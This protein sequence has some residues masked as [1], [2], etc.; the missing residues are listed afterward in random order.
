MFNKNF[1]PTPKPL[2]QRLLK[3]YLNPHYKHHRY[4][5]KYD[6]KGRILDPEAGKG[7]ILDYISDNQKNPQK[8]SFFCIEIEPDLQ[9][10]LRKKNYK[11]IDNDF[12]LYNED[13]YF[14][15]II[16]NPPFDNGA[17]HLLKAI[18]VADNTEIA[19]I[20]N[21]ETIRNE[22]T[23]ERRNLTQQLESYDYKHEFVKDAFTD[24]ERKTNV[25]VVLIWLK[26]PE[27]SNRFD[28][29]FEFEKQKNIDF[30]FDFVENKPAVK[31][32][33]GNMQVQ[34]EMVMSKYVESLKHSHIFNCYYSQFLSDKPSL[35]VNSAK[36][37]YLSMSTSLKKKMWSKVIEKVDIEKYA[38]TKVKKNL[39]RFIEQQCDMAFSKK[40]VLAFIEF[41]TTNKE[42]ILQQAI[43]DVF[44]ILTSRGYTSNRLNIET[45]K[46]N[47]AY[48]VKKKVIAP[49]YIEFGN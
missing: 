11:V 33:I 36:E 25:E 7:D 42:T 9:A 22:H 45:W 17:K 10:I 41:I 43:V 46:T 12:L 29:D 32:L 24:A 8:E 35:P 2:I 28:F 23:K 15:F 1:Y 6:I 30:E 48:K 20:L 39:D 38:T 47:D 34:Y 31:D 18:E 3:P 16:M 27:K 4:A 26:I 5:N 21:A 13:R 37:S 40:N 49:A 14:D 44:D 19:C